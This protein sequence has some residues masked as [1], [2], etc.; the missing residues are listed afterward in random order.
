M[1]CAARAEAILDLTLA[2]AV[3]GDASVTATTRQARMARAG[4]RV[5]RSVIVV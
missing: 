4:I 2:A 5:L 1:P 3:A